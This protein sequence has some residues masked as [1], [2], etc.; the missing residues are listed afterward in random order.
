MASS[1]EHEIATSPG[2][3]LRPRGGQAGR[4]MA[5]RGIIAV[6]FGIIA[7]S[8]PHL[9]VGALVIVF[10]V[11]AFA[12][13]ILDFIAARGFG[14]AGLGWGWYAFAGIASIA[15]GVVALV[16]PRET[17]LVLVLIVGARAI[18]MGFLELGASFSWRTLDSRW[19]LG[20]AGLASIILGILLFASP[21]VGG[22]ALVW[23]I[24]IYAIVFGV[25]IFVVGLRMISRSHHAATS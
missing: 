8:S 13:A 2:D 23:T 22:L 9:V 7:L 5:L 24:G 12:D 14:Q 10:A 25:T 21:S 16:Y 6:I 11:F 3:V 19:L 1:T 20:L 4:V 18:V 17:F 15:A